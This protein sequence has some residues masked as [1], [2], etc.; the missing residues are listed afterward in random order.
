[1]FAVTAHLP[2]Q[3]VGRDGFLQQLR[4][5]FINLSR[6][7]FY[8]IA[9]FA[10]P[11][12]F[13]LV[14]LGTALESHGPHAVAP[15]GP[16]G[17][18]VTDTYMFVH[19]P[20]AGDGTLTAEVTALSGQPLLAPWAKAGIILEPD[21]NQGTDYA[22]VM[23]TGSYGVQAQYNYTQDSPGLSG[24][25][26][27][28]SPRWLRLTRV[29]D[30]ITSYD[31][32]D[33]VHW[34]AIGTARL[35]RLPHTIQIGLFVTSPLYFPAGDNT[36]TSSVATASFDH[37]STQ[38]DLFD[39]AWNGDA[40]AGLYPSQQSD[41]SWQQLS[42]DAFTI[43]GSGD[44]APLVGNIVFSNWSGASI[45]NGTIVGLLI[46]IVLAAMF[47]VSEFRDESRRLTSVPSLQ[48]GLAARTIVVGSLAFAAGVVATAVAEVITRHVLA[49]NGNYVF[50][51]SAS[52][53]ARVVI[54]T[55]LFYC[56]AAAL[57][58]A[59]GTRLRRS[60]LTVA[61]GIALLIV[62]GIV[63]TVSP[64]SE[65]WL[66]SLT[67]TAAFAIQGNLPH[68]DL[69]SGAYTM[70]NGYFPISPWAGLAVL[71]AYAAGAFGAATRLPRRRTP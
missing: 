29:N 64:G 52:D 21:T 48:R 11:L 42:A 22:A 68:S 71:A 46:L 54:G 56:F 37:V 51:Q 5:E 69:V 43:S 19:Q 6:A 2:Q 50:P 35:T 49:A 57:V 44:I 60:A 59:L 62:P 47:G 70:V 24:D 33:G 67:P 8:V 3:P 23:V 66:M 17:E 20:L 9:L 38:G 39:N 31:S 13:V 61:A 15:T 7:R 4:A 34:A 14:S 40:I 1:L 26:R 53:A 36:G 65:I 28:Y 25:P 16:N 12:V 58:V 63:A 45:V 41:S 27:S 30:V 55:G 18:A 10:T 32:T